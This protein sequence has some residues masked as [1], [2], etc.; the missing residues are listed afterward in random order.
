MSN[1]LLSSLSS[2][3]PIRLCE[4]VNAPETTQYVIL[5]INLKKTICVPLSDVR[6]I[7]G[8]GNYTMFYLA[9]GRQVLVTKTIKDFYPIL[10]A[11]VFVRPHR[12]FVVNLRYVEY[13]DLKNMFVQLRNGQQIT[14]SRR[15]KKSFEERTEALLQHWAA[16]S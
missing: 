15:K 7:E 14:I 4:S 5:A 10:E 11:D 2:A 6:Y 3:C 13:L 16:V 12:S 9:D 1:R 8:F